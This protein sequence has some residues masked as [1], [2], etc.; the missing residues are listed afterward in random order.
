MTC[1]RDD[2]GITMGTLPPGSLASKY[3]SVHRIETDASA[4]AKAFSPV[5]GAL[6]ILKEKLE[7]HEGSL[8]DIGCGRGELLLQSHDRF[9]AKVGL[10]FSEEFLH[11]A[12]ALE[13]AHTKGE[14][15]VRWLLH[16]LNEPIPLP[17][18]SFDVAV[19]AAC[20]EHVFDVYGVVREIS[21]LLRRDGVLYLSVPN[22][23][24]LKHRIRL[25]LGRQPVTASSQ[26]LWWRDYWD[27]THMHYF[28]LGS[29]RMLLEQTGFEYAS[30]TGS[31]KL[32]WLRNWMP[33]LLCGDLIVTARKK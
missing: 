11:D 8:I 18:E 12:I 2:S 29:I 22:I 25:L 19:S 15:K 27:G 32:D 16:D 10:D 24:Y 9:A 23:A 21:R 26:E 20:L 30:V 3:D 4:R 14:R 1:E 33:S 6:A 13:N 5:Q 7:K 17:D 31:G 28:T